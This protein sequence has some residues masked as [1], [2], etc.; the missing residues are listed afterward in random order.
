MSNPFT[1]GDLTELS[2][3]SNITSL[4]DGEAKV[5]GYWDLSAQVFKD[6][7]VSV[8]T[9]KTGTG[10]WGAGT[11]AELYIA[12]AEDA[13]GNFTDAIDETADTDQA[14]KITECVLASAIEIAAA[15]T[16]YYFNAFSIAQRLGRSS[17][18]SH[19]ALVLKNGSGTAA[20]DLS[21]TAGDHIAKARKIT[22][23]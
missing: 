1:R 10:T 18:P 22:F 2:K 8:I 5:I 19:I 13:A 7:E 6:V 3:K 11:L 12:I 4:G 16:T 21:A 23:A 14:S 15:S 9:I 20:D 17:M